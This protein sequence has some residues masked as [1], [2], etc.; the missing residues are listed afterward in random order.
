MEKK[1]IFHRRALTFTVD[2][3]LYRC[4]IHELLTDK[5][6]RT[7]PKIFICFQGLFPC[8]AFIE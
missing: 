8:R 1:T 6:L 5:L 7:A 4:R 3:Y 2:R